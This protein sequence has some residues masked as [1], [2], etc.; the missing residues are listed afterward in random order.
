MLTI[1]KLRVL[2]V[3]DVGKITSIVKDH[4]QG[5]AIGEEDGLLNAPDVLIVGLSL[6]GCI[7]KV[8]IATQN[9]KEYLSINRTIDWKTSGSNGGSS[10]V[11]GGENV[12]RAPLD[13]HTIINITNRR[14]T[15]HSMP[16]NC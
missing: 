1:K 3:D 16:F 2:V 5:L 15:I 11:L 9:A 7:Q 10:G 13:L 6:P 14:T 4:V 12:A 8:T